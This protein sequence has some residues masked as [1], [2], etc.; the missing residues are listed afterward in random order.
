MRLTLRSMLAYLDDIL[1]PND[2]AEIREKVEIFYI[3]GVI[4]KI[5]AGEILKTIFLDGNIA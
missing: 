5:M 1:D 2:A 4:Q 3:D